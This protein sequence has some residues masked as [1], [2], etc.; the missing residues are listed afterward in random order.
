MTPQTPEPK[1]EQILAA[2]EAAFREGYKAGYRVGG[3]DQCAYEWGSGSKSDATQQK[4]QDQEWR[5]SESIKICP[6]CGSS[7]TDKYH[8]EGNYFICETDWRKCDDCQHQWDF[9]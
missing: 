1:P 9:Q 4:N 3:D 7:N 8:H 6:N 2:I 5:D